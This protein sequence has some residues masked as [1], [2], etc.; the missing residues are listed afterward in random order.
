MPK[1][2]LHGYHPEDKKFKVTGIL[3]ARD[4]EEAQR[5]IAGYNR[6]GVKKNQDLLIHKEVIQ[7]RG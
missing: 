5:K 6:L 2:T 1:K 3:F 7:K 4:K